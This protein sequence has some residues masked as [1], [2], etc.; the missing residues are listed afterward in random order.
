MAGWINF[1]SSFS[2]LPLLP[3]AL[4][5]CTGHD[6]MSVPVETPTTGET[7]TTEDPEPIPT[8][9]TTLSDDPGTSEASTSTTDPGEG[10]TAGSS[11]TASVEPTCGD[12]IIQGDEKCDDGIAENM[13]GAACL[14][15]C[16]AARCGD[17]FLQAGVE[18]CDLGDGVNA[19]EYGG[20]I[21]KPPARP[22]WRG[23]RVVGQGLGPNDDEAIS[24][25]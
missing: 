25:A 10:S 14:P 15:T 21:R 23:C 6:D 12:G 20:C 18:E 4:G 7:G 17:G 24:K 19:L 13:L 1:K 9:G 8:T 11:T 16:V 5:R 22:F 2:F 3:L